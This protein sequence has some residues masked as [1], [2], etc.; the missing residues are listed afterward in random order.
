MSND[1][2][3]ETFAGNSAL[4]GILATMSDS[5]REAWGIDG[6]EKYSVI[7]VP[8]RAIQL[9]S[10]FSY[11][12]FLSIDVQGAELSSLMSMDWY[13]PIGTICLELEGHHTSADEKCRQLLRSNGFVFR[14]K[15]KISEIW[16]HMDYFRASALYTPSLRCGI[17]SYQFSAGAEPHLPELICL[18]NQ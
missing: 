5:Y 15:L 7:T 11:I 8:M 14:A 12:D 9:A 17:D 6:M 4:S 2:G 10:G 1:Y 3:T 13:C 16:T 18:F